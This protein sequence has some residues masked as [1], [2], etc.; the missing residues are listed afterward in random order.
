VLGLVLSLLLGPGNASAK[1]QGLFDAPQGPL[2]AV[3][4]AGFRDLRFMADRR[5][6]RRDR[7]RLSLR[8]PG[9]PASRATELFH[10]GAF[11]SLQAA[12]HG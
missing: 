3:G 9:V 10:F 7:R 4:W 11:W 5:V 6:R 1:A 12:L 8:R 2:S